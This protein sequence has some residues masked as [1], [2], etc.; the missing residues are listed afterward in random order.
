VIEANDIIRQVSLFGVL[1]VAEYAKTLYPILKEE[2]YD[3][4]DG[5]LFVFP[6]TRRKFAEVARDLFLTVHFERFQFGWWI[7]ADGRGTTSRC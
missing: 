2:G 7:V 3:Q 1:K 6:L 4:R 5:N